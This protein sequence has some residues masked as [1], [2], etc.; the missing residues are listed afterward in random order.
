MAIFFE[1]GY[2]FVTSGRILLD[3]VPAKGGTF[4]LLQKNQQVYFKC[5]KPL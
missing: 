4:V 1:H 2:F 5:F 3:F